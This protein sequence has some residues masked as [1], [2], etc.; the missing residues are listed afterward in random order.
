MSIAA[1]LRVHAELGRRCVLTSGAAPAR[2]EGPARF[3]RRRRTPRRAWPASAP[4]P[5]GQAVARHPAALPT[6]AHRARSNAAHPDTAPSGRAREGRDRRDQAPRIGRHPTGRIE[7]DGAEAGARDASQA[8]REAVAVDDQQPVARVRGRGRR[9]TRE[10][11]AARAPPPR[12]SVVVNDM[13]RALASV[14]VTTYSSGRPAD[15]TSSV[16]LNLT[17]SSMCAA[18]SPIAGSAISSAGVGLPNRPIAIASRLG[19]MAL[20]KAP[21]QAVGASARS[22]IG[23][24]RRAVSASPSAPSPPAT[25][26]GLQSSGSPPVSG[27]SASMVQ[28]RSSWAGSSGQSPRSR[29][30]PAISGRGRQRRDEID[31]R[32]HGEAPDR[33]GDGVEQRQRDLDDAAGRPGSIPCRS[34]Q[35]SAMRTPCASCALPTIA[36]DS[37]RVDDLEAGHAA[38]RRKRRPARTPR[39]GRGGSARSMSAHRWPSRSGDLDPGRRARGR[40]WSAPRTA[41]PRRCPAASA[42]MTADVGLRAAGG[43]LHLENRAEA[44]AVH[45]CRRRRPTRRSPRSARRSVAPWL[46]G[47]GDSGA[48]TIVKV[49]VSPG[50]RDAAAGQHEARES[51]ATRADLNRQGSAVSMAH[52]RVGVRSGRAARAARRRASTAA[53]SRAARACGQT[54]DAFALDQPRAQGQARSPYMPEF[55]H[56]HLHTQYSLLDGAIRLDQLFP[57]G[58]RTRNEDRG[59]DRPRQPVRRARFLPARQ[60]PRREADLRLRDLRRARPPRQD[61]A[62]VEPPHPAREERGRLEEPLVPELDGLPGGL[63]LQPAHRQA[64]AARARRGPGRPVGLPRRRDRADDQAARAGGGRRRPPRSSRTSSARATSSSSCSRTGWRSR[65]RSTATCIEMS[66]KTGIP[67]RRDQRLPLPEPGRR[68]LARDPDVRAAEEDDPRRKADAPPQRRV[69]REDAGGDGGVLQAHPARRW[70]TPRSWARCATSS[71]SWARRSCRSS[72]CPTG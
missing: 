18:S 58:A 72:R 28:S 9:S 26:L 25:A 29:H 38:R 39:D 11:R 67:R 47:S 27:D 71:S 63:L 42:T 16:E 19:A 14:C 46:S 30:G 37:R 12:L 22:V 24:P 34:T 62:P 23:T 69:L 7:G 57:E 48:W 10:A 54:V 4:R 70:R 43:R 59:D 35:P 1:G 51:G 32:G 17:V 6:A 3:H 33:I 64:A 60:G 56:L 44:I 49:T 20:S 55:T 21:R 68:A 15:C 36:L 52:A 50:N 40:R 66:K 13:N 53:R 8:Q 2:V 31:R 41:R 61:R 65:S 5:A 45:L